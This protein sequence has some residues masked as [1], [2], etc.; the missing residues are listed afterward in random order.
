MKIAPVV[1][2]NKRRPIGGGQ[3]RPNVQYMTWMLERS[4]PVSL[5]TRMSL[6]PSL[7][8]HLEFVTSLPITYKMS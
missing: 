5:Q 1:A 6:Q 8:V 3:F 4:T 2:E 7:V